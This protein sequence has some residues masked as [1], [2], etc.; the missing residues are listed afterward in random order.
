MDWLATKLRQAA[1]LLDKAS[2]QEP[3]FQEDALE[4]VMF[5]SAKSVPLQ[6]PYTLSDQIGD[7]IRLHCE[8]YVQNLNGSILEYNATLRR[9]R[10][11]QNAE[12]NAFLDIQ[13][14]KF[15]DMKADTVQTLE[16]TMSAIS[17]VMNAEVVQIYESTTTAITTA[18]NSIVDNATILANSTTQSIT[19]MGGHLDDAYRYSC[20]EKAADDLGGAM[21]SLYDRMLYHANHVTT[22]NDSGVDPITDDFDAPDVPPEVIDVLNLNIPARVGHA[23]DGDGNVVVKDDFLINDQNMA[24]PLDLAEVV[25]S[26]GSFVPEKWRKVTFDARHPNRTLEDW[27]RYMVNSEEDYTAAVITVTLRHV[28]PLDNDVHNDTRLDMHNSGK[29]TRIVNELRSFNVSTFEIR[30][31]SRPVL[32]YRFIRELAR[33]RQYNAAFNVFNVLD[34]RVV[35]TVLL[36]SPELVAQISSPKTWSVDSTASRAQTNLSLAAKQNTCVNL[37]Y[38]VAHS[39]TS[40]YD[41]SVSYAFAK[42]E[43]YVWDNYGSG[44]AFRL[45]ASQ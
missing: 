29:C 22:A 19:T 11:D 24:T 33:Y 45:V 21:D 27:L 28:V 35:D 26:L 1:A 15:Q 5:E 34:H 6:G 17:T 40:I 44:L 25:C 43:K 30:R 23:L 16:S 13:V 10:D 32:I 9:R 42:R 38:N 2:H 4:Y 39:V 36:T 41:D 12:L 18:Q 7:S 31:P 14:N 3:L 20:T 37:P 8:E